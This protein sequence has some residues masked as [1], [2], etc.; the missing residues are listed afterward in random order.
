MGRLTEMIDFYNRSE[1]PTDKELSVLYCSFVP[2]I[3]DNVLT[4]RARRERNAEIKK[5]NK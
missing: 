2:T 1:K 5:L 3:K 4:T